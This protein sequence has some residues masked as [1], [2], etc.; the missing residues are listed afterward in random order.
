MALDLEKLGKVAGIGGIAVGAAVMI[1]RPVIEKAL[2]GLEP[3]AR[4]QAVLVIAIGA[5][6]L[7]ALGIIAWAA[8][9]F[10]R[11]GGQSARAGRDAAAAGRDA[12]VGSTV[13]GQSRRWAPV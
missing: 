2:P 9:A 1:L 5:F 8:S 7:G 4:A 3:G 13:S 12:I 10:V 6:V 11:R